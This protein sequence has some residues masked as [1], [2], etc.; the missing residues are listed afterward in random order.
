M[1]ADKDKMVEV[2]DSYWWHVRIVYGSLFILTAS[3]ISSFLIGLTELTRLRRD[4]DGLAAVCDGVVSSTYGEEHTTGGSA[5]ALELIL[6]RQQ[7]RQKYEY[8]R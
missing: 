3:F 6:E 2:P 8:D 1:R 5:R 4:L 7:Q